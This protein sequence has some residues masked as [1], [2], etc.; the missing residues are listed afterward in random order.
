MLHFPQRDLA[1]SGCRRYR[2]I[3]ELATFAQSDQARRKSDLAHWN[4]YAVAHARR[5][6]EEPHAIADSA[7]APGHLDGID[8]IS[9]TSSQS[10]VQP[11]HAIE[12]VDRKQDTLR[13]R[14]RPSRIPLKLAKRF[15]LEIAPEAA[16]FRS[17][18]KPMKLGLDTP[19]K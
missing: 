12:I 3:S 15:D 18:R 7:R 16:C 6:S 5:E 1:G 19:S 17:L 14:M 9:P 8:L 11:G 4:H 13:Q 10:R 2:R